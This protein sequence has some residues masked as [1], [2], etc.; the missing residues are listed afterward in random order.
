M[1]FQG[2]LDTGEIDLFSVGI[3]GLSIAEYVLRLRSSHETFCN[4]LTKTISI[5]SIG[6]TFDLF[7]EASATIALDA[8]VS[9]G[10]HYELN[11]LSFTVG[12]ST[13]STPGFTPLDSRELGQHIFRQYPLLTSQLKAVQFSIDPS[14]TANAILEAH[15]IPTVWSLAC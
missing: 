15:L 5:L 12:S 4:V 7:G 6:P 10:V 14:I 9:V 13:T 3:P 8:D 1:F 2:T 11:G